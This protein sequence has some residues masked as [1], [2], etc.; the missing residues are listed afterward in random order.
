M[1]MAREVFARCDMG[2]LRTQHAA[3]LENSI[4]RFKISMPPDC[5]P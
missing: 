5:T 3:Q 2:E 1:V 4:N